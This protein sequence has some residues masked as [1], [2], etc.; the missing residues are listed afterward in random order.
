MIIVKNVVGKNWWTKA[1]RSSVVNKCISQVYIVCGMG[2]S[3][4][5]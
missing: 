1:E 5:R 2:G 4:N 3:V